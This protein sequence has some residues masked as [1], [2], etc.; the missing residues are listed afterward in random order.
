[1]VPVR[2]PVG[3]LDYTWISVYQNG[4]L[5]S[6]SVVGIPT[7]SRGRFKLATLAEVVGRDRDARRAAVGAAI[8]FAQRTSMH[9]LI[10]QSTSRLL[11]DALRANGFVAIR[12]T[13]LITRMLG[14]DCFEANPFVSDAWELFGGDFDIL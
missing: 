6:F 14:A 1:L 13:P 7:Q 10:T 8:R 5:S 11:A 12:K 4:A 3:K 9:A 2:I